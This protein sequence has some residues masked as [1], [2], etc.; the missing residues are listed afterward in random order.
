MKH[1]CLYC[2]EPKWFHWLKCDF[3]RQFNQDQTN[4]TFANYKGMYQYLSIMSAS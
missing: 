3:G 2:H 1:N 4:I